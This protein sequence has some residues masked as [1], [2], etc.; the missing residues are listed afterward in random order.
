MAAGRR[1]ILTADA[2]CRG[3]SAFEFPPLTLGGFMADL[4]KYRRDDQAAVLAGLGA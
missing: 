3:A 2:G 1:M 4:V